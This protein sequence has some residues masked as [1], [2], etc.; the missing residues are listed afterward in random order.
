M[1]VINIFSGSDFEENLL[2]KWE[3]LEPGKTLKRYTFMIYLN[4]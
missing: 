2:E 1:E 3:D 4:R